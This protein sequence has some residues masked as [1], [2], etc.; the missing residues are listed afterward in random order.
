MP[1]GLFSLSGIMRFLNGD[2]RPPLGNVPWPLISPRGHPKVGVSRVTGALCR[3]F[4]R[5]D[6]LIFSFVELY[7]PLCDQLS[8]FMI[9]RELRG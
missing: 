1:M 5:G 4:S 6:E 9:S 7:F 3:R 8:L 2:P